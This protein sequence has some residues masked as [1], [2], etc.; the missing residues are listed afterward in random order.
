[1]LPS[2]NLDDLDGLKT[3]IDEKASDLF[4]AKVEKPQ[5]QVNRHNIEVCKSE[6]GEYFHQIEDVWDISKVRELQVRRSSF[7]TSMKHVQFEYLMLN[8][9]IGR[10]V[11]SVFHSPGPILDH[12]EHFPGII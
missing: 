11:A 6:K 9:E 2:L 8:S 1:M 5:L 3:R 10:L 7:P 12:I 4:L